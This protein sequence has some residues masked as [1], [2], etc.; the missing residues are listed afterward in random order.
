[1]SSIQQL[2]YLLAVDRFR[3]FGKAADSCHVTQPTL[4]MQI[5]K[6]EEEMGVSIFDR[7]KK[8]ILPTDIGR[9]VI[10]QARVVV[11]EFKKIEQLKEA[12]S[13]EIK[14]V[15]RL[16]II[17]TL[18]GS[19][20]PLF[21]EK[22]L[23]KYPDL[24]LEFSEL[25]T[26]QCLDSLE[27][28]QLD[29]AILVTPLPNEQFEERVLF[30]EPF[31]V[32]AN[33]AHPLGKLTKVDEKD[34]EAS[35][36]WL[37]SEGHCFRNQALRICGKKGKD[38]G[39]QSKIKLEGG[40]LSTLMKIV[41]RLGGFTLLPELS[42]VD[43]RV[44]TARVVDFRPPYPTREVSLVYRRKQLKDRLLAALHAVIRESLPE[45]ITSLKRK[46]LQLV[47]IE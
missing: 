23:E 27:I 32:Y 4:S 43:A 22:C 26:Q 5:Q 13:S 17:P 29:A 37:L 36:L 16:G 9:K 30:Y 11:A 40:S 7:S 47:R 34:L 10:D 6:L 25:Q 21:A 31:F 28:D 19:V 24:K 18:S 44:G 46:D 15:L 39:L 33:S 2:E 14:G 41:E 45:S 3:H 8:P 42:R 38:T 1:M 35:G 20:I 12:E